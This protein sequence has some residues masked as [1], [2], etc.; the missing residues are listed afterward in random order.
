MDGTQITRIPRLMDGTQITR[1]PRLM[2]GTQ[3]TRISSFITGR[4][5]RGSLHY[6]GTRIARIFMFAT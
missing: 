3:I 4:G 5:S 6:H 1:I 2:D